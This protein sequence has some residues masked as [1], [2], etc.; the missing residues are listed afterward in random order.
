LPKSTSK[1]HLQRVV[2]RLLDA[3]PAG[4]E[5]LQRAIKRREMLKEV[6]QS[7]WVAP[8][9]LTEKLSSFIDRLAPFTEY[10]A[11]SPEA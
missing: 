4:K 1:L 10:K 8:Y 5:L 3:G 7:V 11:I 2:S 9:F 6:D